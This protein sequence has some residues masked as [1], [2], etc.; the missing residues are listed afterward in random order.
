MEITINDFINLISVFLPAEDAWVEVA[1]MNES[2][3]GCAVAAYQGKIFVTGGF[4]SEKNILSTSEVFDPEVGKW[5]K[6]PS[7]KGMN[8]F[9]GGV[10]VDRPIHLEDGFS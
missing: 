4:G 3:F 5:S 7:M 8:G 2:R 9:V 10:L 6:I 1:P